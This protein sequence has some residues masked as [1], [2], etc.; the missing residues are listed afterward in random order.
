MRGVRNE[1]QAG[2]SRLALYRRARQ[3]LERRGR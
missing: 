3:Q 1:A 2:L